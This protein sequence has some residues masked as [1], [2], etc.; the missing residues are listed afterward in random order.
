MIILVVSNANNFAFVCA[1]SY[2]ALQTPFVKVLQETNI[3]PL[4]C[5]ITF[6]DYWIISSPH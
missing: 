1:L 4:P 5:Q 2:N 3:I 6:K